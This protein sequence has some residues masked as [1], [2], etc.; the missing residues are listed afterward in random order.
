M[1]L[2]MCGTAMTDSYCFNYTTAT[3]TVH[4]AVIDMLLG[5]N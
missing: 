3:M 1:A 5:G 2:L 4:P